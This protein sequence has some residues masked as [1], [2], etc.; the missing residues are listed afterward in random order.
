MSEPI[1]IP[2]VLIQAQ[3]HSPLKIMTAAEKLHRLIQA[4]SESQINEV[5][6]FAEFLQ[7]K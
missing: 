5:L 4:L 1:A 7:Q 6:D 3:T 2:P